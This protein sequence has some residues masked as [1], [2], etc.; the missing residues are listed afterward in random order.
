MIPRHPTK[1]MMSICKSES[2]SSVY[3]ACESWINLNAKVESGFMFSLA[4]DAD[5]GVGLSHGPV[6]LQAPVRY[7]KVGYPRGKDLQDDIT[8]YTVTH[9]ARPLNHIWKQ[10]D[11]V[12]FNFCLKKC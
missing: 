6:A 12:I 10:T 7:I 11:I 3:L 8:R 2:E 9:I 5:G 4:L 1:T